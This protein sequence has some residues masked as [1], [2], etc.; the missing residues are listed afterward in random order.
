MPSIR[1][2]VYEEIRN[3]GSRGI[4]DIGARVQVYRR[5]DNDKAQP[6]EFLGNEH[7]PYVWGGKYDGWARQYV[8]PPDRVVTLSCHP[9]Q[10]GLIT[11]HDPT[12]KVMRVLSI[13]AAG[14]GKTKGIILK[15]ILEGIKDA[16]RIVG[17]VAPTGERRKIAWKK[18]LEVVKPLGWVARVYP[19]EHE[20]RLINGTLYQFRAAKKA[21]DAVGTP[22]QGYDWDVA[23]E[24]EQQNISDE[25]LTEVD[26]RGRRAGTQYRVYSSAT[27][28]LIP[29][30]QARLEEYKKR[31]FAKVI[32][33][34][35]YDNVWIETSYW[36]RFK[37][38][39]SKTQF[40]RLI[41]GES[42]P[43][44][45]RIYP[46]FDDENI[47]PRPVHRKDITE[48]VTFD[49]YD[50]PFRYIVGQD[51][52]ARVN[53]SAV[54][55]CYSGDGLNDRMWWAV[56]EYQTVDSA[57]ITAHVPRLI[58]WMAETF[59]AKVGEFIVIGDPHFGKRSNE[60]VDESD[61]DVLRNSGIRAEPASWK[62]IPKRHRFGMVNTLLQDA[63]GKR[64]LFVERDEYG[65]PVCPKMVN[66]FRFYRWS[67][68]RS[69]E[70][71]QFNKDDR[72]P[73]HYTDVCYAL[74]P[75]E[76][77]RGSETLTQLT[78]SEAAEHKWLRDSRVF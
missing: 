38:R 34:S 35:G 13:G 15:A 2:A 69:G 50:H 40:D 56:G 1:K 57:G 54:F 41:K 14:G 23:V 42:P 10:V 68:G 8:G 29:E 61:Y 28:Q 11:F 21:S 31:D 53:A 43:V 6:A 19:V 4:V 37:G 25:A 3:L 36:D 60:G 46:C 67:S 64:R 18:F 17:V 16:N 24:D 45:G 47:K 78:P 62:Q 20:I 70:P 30:F 27:N 48:K 77:F 55:K 9:G 39:M 5:G 73:S 71:E 51:F 72:D 66:S 58:A 75:W 59:N 49:I 76:E 74:Y 12:G 22:I 33:F 65:Q 44:E 52:G 63:E 32:G 7:G 26:L